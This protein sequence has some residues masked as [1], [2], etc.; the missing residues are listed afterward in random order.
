MQQSQSTS[1]E[2]RRGAKEYADNIL[3]KVQADLENL[4]NIIAANREELK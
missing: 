4:R 1:K 2:I 3:G